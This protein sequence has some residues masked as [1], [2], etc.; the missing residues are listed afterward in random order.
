[1][2]A[3]N[4]AVELSEQDVVIEGLA[5]V[6]ADG[7][8][9]RRAF[10]VAR[11]RSSPEPLRI[12][13][14]GTDLFWQNTSM[15]SRWTLAVEGL[16]RIDRAEVE[17]G[18]L[19]LFV[20]DN[21]SGKTY[22]A[23]LL[24]DFYAR[25]PEVFL[26]D[27]AELEALQASSRYQACTRWLDEL[28]RSEPYTLTQ[29]D[30]DLILAWFNERLDEKKDAVVQR[31][32][33]RPGMSIRGMRVQ[34]LSLDA[35]ISLILR[36]LPGGPSIEVA[37]TAVGYAPREPRTLEAEFVPNPSTSFGILVTLV[38]QLL[39]PNRLV[40]QLPRGYGA[41][42]PV[43]FP[44]SR[45]GFM[46]LYKDV[47]ADLID[48]TTRGVVGVKS[49]P[50]SRI[51]LT[52]PVAH[53]LRLLA[54][55][56]RPD[57]IG[58]FS[59]EA[60]LIE[61]YAFPG[62]VAL[63]GGVGVNEVEYHYSPDE[64]A[65]P[66]RLSS[67]LVTELAPLILVLRH[68]DSLPMLILEEPEA[69]LHPKL[70]RK[71]AR[72]IARLVRKGVQVCI[73]THSPDFCQPINNLIKLGSLAPEARAT[74]QA[75]YG[76]EPQDYLDQ[77]EVTGHEFHVGGQGRSTVTRLEGSP[78]GLAIPTFNEELFALSKE[79]LELQGAVEGST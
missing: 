52:V 75:K 4:V 76:Y 35:S 70:Q 14:G 62:T 49:A 9:A 61:R 32:F 7:W 30:I 48:W 45:T 59:T 54:V 12:F 74:L 56:L 55:G 47:L 8:S 31:I 19:T 33:G 72:V 64:L 69:H 50:I 68:A 65:L 44:A 42:D 41:G 77:S 34:D 13:V 28:P 17:V 26:S 10:A 51:Q 73:T 39:S 67:S 63:T 3:P 5:R 24:W 79:A 6:V 21:N 1:M 11:S 78:S 40:G 20:G 15:R 71:L 60:D 53:F 27:R 43:Y 29:G 38:A 18:S 22:L 2:R 37:F 23:S 57:K 66:M 25:M 58:P 36:P 16:G 46:L